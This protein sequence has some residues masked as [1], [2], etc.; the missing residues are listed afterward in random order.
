MIKL[1]Y[2]VEP[3]FESI[4]D[5]AAKEW[6]NALVNLYKLEKA[7]FGDIIIKTGKIDRVKYPNRIAECRHIG[8]F[9]YIIMGDHVNWAISSFKRFFGMGEDALACTVHEFGHVFD[10]PH[11]ADPNYVMHPEIGG[12]GKLS[13]EEKKQYRNFILNNN[14]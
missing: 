4:A 10:L 8:N 9:W 2:S 12:T 3:K 14:E 13:N 7:D 1:Q 5:K 6:N 11:A